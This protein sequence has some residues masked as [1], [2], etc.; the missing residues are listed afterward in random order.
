MFEQDLFHVLL[1]KLQARAG[2]AG[3]SAAKLMV[4]G[5]NSALVCAGFVGAACC[6]P[7]TEVAIRR[8]RTYRKE[9]VSFAED[10]KRQTGGN[11]SA[12]VSPLG[13]YLLRVK[14]S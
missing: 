1:I 3:G 8:R 4:Y 14:P 12:Q 11:R 7:A 9:A 13:S 6:A 2:G 10:N 5:L